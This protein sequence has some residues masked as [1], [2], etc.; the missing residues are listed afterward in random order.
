MHI[1]AV[2]LRLLT[3]A[4]MYIPSPHTYSG[5]PWETVTLKTFGR[6]KNVFYDILSQVSSP[7]V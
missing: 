7:P 1:Y 6:S 2:F 3:H 4:L 5:L